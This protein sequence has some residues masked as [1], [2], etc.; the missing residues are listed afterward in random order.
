M[1]QGCQD[2]DCSDG[3]A[4]L[5]PELLRR[6][7]GTATAFIRQASTLAA[8]ALRELGSLRLRRMCEIPETY[9]PPKSLGTICWRGCGGATLTRTIRLTNTSGDQ[10]TYSLS[11]A[12]I[13][14]P[15]GGVLPVTLN[16]A[17]LALAG[18]ATGFAKASVVIPEDFPA[19]H[20]ETRILVVGAYEQHI[21]V[22]L[23]VQ[24]PQECTLAV[25]QGDIPVRIKAH[26]WYHHFQCVERCF[27]PAMKRSP[28]QAVAGERLDAKGE[29]MR[30]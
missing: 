2:C 15:G 4:E 1:T 20:Y 12:P 3:A 26:R 16:P 17:H 30:P 27:P 21:D 13:A 22:E 14:A 5:G 24:C 7:A 6:S 29:P 28:D 10:H 9:C 23:C 19:G 8:S 25:A 11:A 18:G